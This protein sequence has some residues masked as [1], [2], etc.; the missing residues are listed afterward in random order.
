MRAPSNWRAHLFS[1]VLGIDDRKAQ[2]SCNFLQRDVCGHQRIHSTTIP[3]AHSHRQLDRIERS[4]AVFPA[5]PQNQFLR[6]REML[7]SDA[8]RFHDAPRK[9]LID[10]PAQSQHRLPLQDTCPSLD[11]QC[12]MS[13]NN[14]QRRYSNYAPRL[15]KDRLDAFRTV[16]T[17]IPLDKRARVEK[18]LSQ[19]ILAAFGNDVV[20][21]VAWYGREHLVHLFE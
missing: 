17:V 4:Q 16:L 5:K 21:P 3:Q 20:R 15:C 11:R 14:P 9:V 7:R 19:S 8:M 18:V 10:E 1:A 6:F 2:Q 12:R 13:F